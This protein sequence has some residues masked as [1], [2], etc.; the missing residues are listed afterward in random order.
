MAWSN[1]VPA[2]ASHLTPIPLAYHTY[3]QQNLP[4][5]KEIV[6]TALAALTV[7]LPTAFASL[8]ATDVTK[9]AVSTHLQTALGAPGQF[10]ITKGATTFTV[11]YSGQ[12]GE[13]VLI[14]VWYM[15]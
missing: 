15:P 10:E 11:A 6:T 14:L 5:H 13:S 12:V 4:V 3:I 8:I 1:W 2:S 9:Y 7:T